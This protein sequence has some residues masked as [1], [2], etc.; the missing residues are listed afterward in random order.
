VVEKALLA[1]FYFGCGALAGAM[2]QKIAYDRERKRL[3]NAYSMT[4]KAFPDATGA[5]IL[6]MM[7]QRY[8]RVV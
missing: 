5:E 8:Q 4:R 1:V 6:D 7:W 2:I 3:A